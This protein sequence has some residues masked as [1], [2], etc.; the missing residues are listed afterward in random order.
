[1]RRHPITPRL[2][3]VTNFYPLVRL[4]TIECV[5]SAMKNETLLIEIKLMH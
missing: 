4:L 5:F 2:V 3:H 1:M